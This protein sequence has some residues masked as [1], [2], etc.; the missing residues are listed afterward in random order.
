MDT[1]GRD[2]TKWTK[3]DFDAVLA[4][5]NPLN[6]TKLTTNEEKTQ[7]WR[8]D[9]ITKGKNPPVYKRWTDDDERELLEASKEEITLGDTAL[10]RVQK[11]KSNEVRRSI[12]NMPDAE[13]AELVA[14]RESTN[15][16]SH[17]SMA[18]GDV[19]EV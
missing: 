17:D 11:R 19:G 16:Y 12:L 14:A 8:N 3:T 18:E 5:Y 13:W 6:R 1:K 7:A 2:C 15:N 4:W 10:G 9:I